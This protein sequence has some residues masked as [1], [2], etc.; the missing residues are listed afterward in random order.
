M[1]R[2]FLFAGLV[3]MLGVSLSVLGLARAEMPGPDAAALWKYITEESPYTQWS[4]WPDHKGMQPGRSPHGAFHK[5][6]VNKPA[7]E[8]TSVP[9]PD[10]SIVVK[11][12]F[13]ADKKMAALTIMYKVKGYDPDNGDWYYAKYDPDGTIGPAGKVRG[14]IACHAGNAKNDYIFVHA[15]K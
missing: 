8:A 15:F 11:E 14:C 1:K 5:V 4:F 10:G 12:N 13:T 9:I 7:L 6:L 3:A 2:I